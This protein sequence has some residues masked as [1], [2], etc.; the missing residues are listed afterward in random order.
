VRL[1]IA[2]KVLVGNLAVATV[3]AAGGLWMLSDLRSIDTLA[4]LTADA[5]QQVIAIDA[6][7]EDMDQARRTWGPL[8]VSI[9]GSGREVWH[10]PKV[11][12]QRRR[13]HEFRAPRDSMI[14]AVA[15][16]SFGARPA[17]LA[18]L[19]NLLMAARDLD[20]LFD[21]AE[22]LAMRG[23]H[24]KAE[25]AFANRFDPDKRLQA[26]LEQVR[27]RAREDA[28]HLIEAAEQFRIEFQ[29]RSSVVFALMFLLVVTTVLVLHRSIRRS[30]TRLGET[31]AVVAEG[32]F[33][34][35]A[36]IAARDEFRDIADSVNAMSL[37]LGELDELKSEF[38]SSVSHELRTPIASVKQAAALL[39]EGVVGELTED[40]REMVGIVISNSRRLGALI[41]DLLD[42]AR[43][44]AG[45][46][47]LNI[48]PVD[49][50]DLI[51]EV[52]G[53][54]APLAQEKSIVVSM[55]ASDDT[56]MAMADRLRL[57]QV[58]VNL[59]SNAI[60]FTPEEGR[61][62]IS[63]GLEPDG[64]IRCSV[65]DTG[66]GMPE[67][68][69]PYVFD[70]FH[71]V[72]AARTNKLK[73]TGLGLTIVKYLVEAHGGEVSVVSKVDEGTTFAFTV[74]AGSSE[75]ASA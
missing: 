29:R 45:R 60:K 16:S 21:E 31:L 66:I 35:R 62:D 39:D 3:V 47:D 46:V 13:M 40:Q 28:R 44:E 64:M 53:T 23:E 65:S 14:Q 24:D 59:L 2:A 36:E 34:Q 20:E 32:R 70:K 26:A 17:M 33:D 49:I 41:N 19:K 5:Q 48:A 68:E 7:A 10:D 67:D 69:L 71:Q 52:A 25:R 6:I 55:N 42:T 8:I 30:T 11:S 12:S 1:T 75:D 37:R 72:R 58:L 15:T 27:A 74:P 9:M 54:L 4:A 57:E 61:I 43:L 50:P 22:R 73:G 56:P 63:C 18:S 38:L 51:R